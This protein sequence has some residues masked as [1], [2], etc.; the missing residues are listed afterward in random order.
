MNG[1]LKRAAYAARASA[2]SPAARATSCST[3]GA[4]APAGASTGGAAHARGQR[5]VMYAEL[6]AHSPC[7]A[8]CSHC[9]E[10]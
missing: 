6:E 7:A 9:C 10:S 3:L 4:H 5:L 2:Y 1:P 8:H